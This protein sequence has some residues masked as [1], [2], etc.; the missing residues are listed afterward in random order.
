MTAQNPSVTEA[1]CKA[2]YE[3]RI[4]GRRGQ[5]CKSSEM[6]VTVWKKYRLRIDHELD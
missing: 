3:S 5:K 1:N 6:D 4:F 2:G